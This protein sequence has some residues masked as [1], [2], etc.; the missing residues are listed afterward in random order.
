MKTIV[1]LIGASNTSNVGPNGFNRDWN[2]TKDSI[3][4]NIIEPLKQYCEVSTHIATYENEQVNDIVHFYNV[5]SGIVL[6][7]ENSHQRLTYILALKHLLESEIDFDFVVTTRF[8]I[9]FFNPL[10][11]YDFNKVNF[12]FKD[13]D[14]L[15]NSSKYTG[16]CLFGI[17]KTYIQEFIESVENAHKNNEWYMHQIYNNLIGK[18]SEDNCYFLFDGNHASNENNIY[19]LVR[20]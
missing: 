7:Y 19:Q 20:A 4:L 6:P 1:Y 14:T 15:W 11:H 8:D 16:D 2:L 3:K 18:I 9:D 13:V 12:L 10:N 5:E 17:P